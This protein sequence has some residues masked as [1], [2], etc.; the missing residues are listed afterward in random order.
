MHL[1]MFDLIASL[2]EPGSKTAQIQYNKKGWVVHPITNVWGYTSPGEAASWG[3]HTGAPAWI[4]QHIGEHYRFTGDKDFLRKTYPVLKGA[5]EFYMDWLTENPKTKELVSG[6][7][8]SPENTFVAPDGSHS[9]ISMGPAHDQQTIWQLFDDF[10]MISSELSI[11]DDFTRQ[12]ADAKDRLAD[13]KIGSDGRIMEWADEFPEVEPGHRHISHLFAI[14]PGSQINMLRNSRPD[15][16][17]QQIAGLPH[18]ASQRLCRLEFGM[19]HQPICPLASGRKSEREPGRCHEEMHQPE[20]LHN[21]S[22]FP[23]R[24]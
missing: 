1:P 23:D 19:G 7:A 17:S 3:M 5:I 16:G 9:Q 14:H 6:P 10:A 12:V 11:D 22:S 21:M 18:P 8:V 20:P 15:R 13:T 4:C 2:V 24:R